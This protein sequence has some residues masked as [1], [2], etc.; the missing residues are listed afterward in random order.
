M[1]NS[2]KPCACTMVLI[3]SFLEVEGVVRVVPIPCLNEGS[4]IIIRGG[5]ARCTYAFT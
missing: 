2:L 4:S 3:Y 1:E 5:N